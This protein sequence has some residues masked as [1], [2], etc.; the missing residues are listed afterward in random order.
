MEALSLSSILVKLAMTSDL[1]VLSPQS[2]DTRYKYFDCS[3]YAVMYRYLTLEVAKSVL[4]LI[5]RRRPHFL[6]SLGQ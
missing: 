1:E 2:L 3:R 4:H 6:I 5:A